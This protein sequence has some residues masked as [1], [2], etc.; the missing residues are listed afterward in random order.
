[1]GT[2]YPRMARVLALAFAVAVL[3]AVAVEAADHH[4]TSMAVK[5]HK[6]QFRSGED[7]EM[8][9]LA[10][11]VRPSSSGRGRYRATQ[12][13]PM[14]GDYL[15]TGAYYCDVEIGSPSKTFS[16]LVDTGSSN[17]AVPSS[18]CTNCGSNPG[19]V[20]YDPSDSSSSDIPA[21]TST[22]CQ[23]CIPAGS[24]ATECSF[25]EPECD[26]SKSG[27]CPF[28]ITYGGGSS[29][30]GG[31]YATDKVC[32]G[33]ACADGAA[34]GQILDEVYFESTQGP[35]LGILG[36]ASSANACNPSCVPTL[37]DSLVEAEA[38]ENEFGMC[39]TT[40]GGVIDLGF[41]NASRYEGELS[42]V[43]IVRPTW[44]ELPLIDVLVGTTSVGAPEFLF[45]ATNDV[46]GSFIDSGTSVLLFGPAIA[47]AIQN[48]FQTV[49]A[50]LPGM[51]TNV[52]N[53]WNGNCFNNSVI[54]PKIDEYPDLVYVFSGEDGVD[55]TIPVAADAYL[56]LV[57]EMRCLG[58]AGVPSLGAI[59]G[60]IFLQSVYAHY[61]RENERVGFAP[62]KAAECA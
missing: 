41:A 26:A 4:K 57:D 38:T 28:G 54:E 42:Y 20:T 30:L 34:V 17:L 12:T 23:T 59:M 9:G 5:R 61:D 50:D 58:I 45:T 62:A 43:P 27:G 44:Y 7:D 31:E 35:F 53:F 39:F 6:P 25:G 19:T 47:S 18:A 3:V 40:E 21:C 33:S 51:S 29:A 56:M 2:H 49:Y 48:I 36:L 11:S 52:D 46:I 14:G 24:D 60:D 1:M 55:V 10:A 22:F 15:T 16:V 8:E 32:L 37:L 13:I